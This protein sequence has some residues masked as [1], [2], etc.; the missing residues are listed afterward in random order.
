V[1][2]VIDVQTRVLPAFEQSVEALCPRRSGQVGSDQL[3]QLAAAWCSKSVWRYRSGCGRKRG[4][5][6]RDQGRRWRRT[7]RH[8]RT[9][10]QILV[11]QLAQILRFV[12][13]DRHKV[14]LADDRDDVRK[15]TGFE[16]VYTA[17]V[18]AR[19]QPRRGW[20]GRE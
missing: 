4:S 6:R 17:A 8:G 2:R 1:G 18:E 11:E 19:S 12:A 15:G 9:V 20:P 10:T 7:S 16:P 5:S 13:A 14:G 3:P